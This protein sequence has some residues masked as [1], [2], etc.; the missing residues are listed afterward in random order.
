M[1]RAVK[2]P[3]LKPILT[4]KPSV[5]RFDERRLMQATRVKRSELVSHF[6][7][8]PAAPRSLNAFQVDQLPRPV[9]RIPAAP[10][11]TQP[12]SPTDEL[13]ERALLR[14]DSHRQP[15]VKLRKKSLKRRVGA[16]G[17]IALSVLAMLVVIN[18]NSTDVRLQTA[19]SSAGFT[20]SLPTNLPAGFSR[21]QFNYSPGI[22]SVGFQSKDQRAFALI[23]KSTTWDAKA[24]RDNFVAGQD[25]HF[26]TTSAAGHTVYIFG[27]H[28]AAWISGK[29]WYTVQN[30]GALTDLQ[31]INLAASS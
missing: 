29:I 30:Y 31:L 11:Q 25:P 3:A 10:T 19:S 20:A 7:T 1:R 18:Q 13:L 16:A 2:K 28:N 17:A 23:Q 5:K 9:S 8:A 24:L 12:K 4:P 15:P 22:V 14:A 27:Q 26:Q 6:S 21:G